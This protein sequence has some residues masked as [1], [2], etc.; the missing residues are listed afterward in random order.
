MHFG[1]TPEWLAF[2][3]GSCASVDVVAIVIFPSSVGYE[4][5]KV[6]ILSKVFAMVGTHHH[7]EP[8]YIDASSSYRRN[9]SIE[10]FPFTIFVGL[11]VTIEALG[12]GVPLFLGNR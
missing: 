1:N 5:L 8:L 9:E 2:T 6:R 11:N 12:E 3:Y 10:G 4:R 7:N